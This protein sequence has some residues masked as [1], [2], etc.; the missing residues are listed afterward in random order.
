MAA[1]LSRLA[2]ISSLTV[3][4]TRVAPRPRTLLQKSWIILRHDGPGGVLRSA[5]A[6]R[7]GPPGAAHLADLIRLRCPGVAHLYCEDLHTAQSRETIRQL[8]PD[9]G[10][11][12]AS[13]VLRP[14]VF[15]IP[16]LGCLNLH[17]GHAPEFRG[18]SPGFYEMLEGVPSVGITVHRVTTALDGGAIFAQERFPLHLAPPDDPIEHL[19][20]Y[21]ELTLVPHGVRMMAEVVAALAWGAVPERA[22]DA[23][24]ARTRRR[25]TWRLKRRL[26]RVVRDRRRALDRERHEIPAERAPPG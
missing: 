5:L 17:F 6:R 14:E 13:Y 2:E 11:V 1:G 23:A 26:R 15:T 3:V 18:S 10:V 8:A 24:L 12:A 9:L 19:R 16:R 4:T 21:Q 22:Q 20:R 7:A 25:A